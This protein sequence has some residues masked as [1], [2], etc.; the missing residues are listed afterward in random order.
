MISRGKGWLH[1]WLARGVSAYRCRSVLRARSDAIAISP[2]PRFG[3]SRARRRSR[4]VLAAPGSRTTT[5]W[6]LPAR[7]TG[8]PG[9]RVT[10]TV[11]CTSGP[12]PIAV[13][14][15][16]RYWRVAAWAG[17]LEGRADRAI[18]A[19]AMG[20]ARWHGGQPLIRWRSCRNTAPSIRVNQLALVYQKMEAVNLMYNTASPCP[21]MYQVIPSSLE[22]LCYPLG[23]CGEAYGPSTPPQVG[24]QGG[25]FAAPLQPPPKK[26]VINRIWYEWAALQ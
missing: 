3:L 13:S 14:W 16:I 21:P 18:T 6:T 25:G 7:K 8:S 26:Q 9:K 23:R 4:R 2:G 24:L 15:S 22:R 11:L 1:S 5:F 19:P 17:Q 10:P 20:T 12:S